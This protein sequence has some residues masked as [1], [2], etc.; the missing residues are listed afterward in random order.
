MTGVNNPSES[1]H[2][3][4]ETSEGHDGGVDS[5][6][7][8]RG[9]RV[10][11]SLRRP[12]PFWRS[13]AFAVVAALHAAGLFA[14]VTWEISRPESV[15]LQAISVRLLEPDRPKVAEAKPQFEPP[16]P[17][18]K[19]RAPEP[20][21]PVLAAAQEAPTAPTAMTVPPQPAPP[22][23]TE[24]AAAPVAPALTE[25]RFDADYLQNPKP[26]YPRT[27]RR[28]EE[29][30]KVLLRVHVAAD[31]SAREI[32]IKQSSGFPRLDAAAREAV[33]R[34]KFVPARRGPDAV[35][36][37]VAVPIVFSLTTEERS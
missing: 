17:T 12:E 13:P 25:A 34:W 32:E 6:A 24:A 36:S 14:L 26:V 2:A 19:T 16:K 37:W 23:R 20:P 18:P 31:G 7:H 21:R 15:I 30:G 35:D 8:R 4:P 33:A 22:A 1:Q 3:C 27:S 10:R 5:A 11:T 28:L 9:M 29:Q